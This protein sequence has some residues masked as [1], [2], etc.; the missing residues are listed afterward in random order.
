MSTKMRRP[1]GGVRLNPPFRVPARVLRLPFGGVFV[2]RW[3]NVTAWECKTCGA[4]MT[5][6]DVHLDWHEQVGGDRA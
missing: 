6:I 5:D 2:L 1:L 4:V 3:E